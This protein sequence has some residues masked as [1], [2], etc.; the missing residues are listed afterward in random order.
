MAAVSGNPALLLRALAREA[1]LGAGGRGFVRYMPPGGALL[2]TDALARASD[3]AQAGRLTDALTAAGFVSAPRGTLLGLMPSDALLLRAAGEAAP[4]ALIDWDG[5]LL[6]AQALAARWL[7]KPSL[8]LTD[9]GRALAT[10]T[11]R[12]LWQPPERVMA[13]L[14]GLRALAA[15]NLRAGDASGAHEAGCYLSAWLLQATRDKE[16][17]L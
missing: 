11:L 15:E 10:E 7:K 5:P 1:V 12:L 3:A 17:G 9:A 6:P 4:P 14:S 16:D 13:G 8:P 2:A